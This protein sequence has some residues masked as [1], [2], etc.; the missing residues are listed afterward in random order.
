[1]SC[2]WTLSLC[3]A[4]CD[5]VLAD[6]MADGTPLP[7]R[8]VGLLLEPCS[9]KQALKEI[10]VLDP[11]TSG[12]AIHLWD[13]FGAVA[14]LV[15][16]PTPGLLACHHAFHGHKAKFSFPCLHHAAIP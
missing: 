2:W 15:K 4:V 16:V 7:A 8:W 13:A 11:A 14:S 3:G 9:R 6:I 12:V 5:R 10:S 1:M